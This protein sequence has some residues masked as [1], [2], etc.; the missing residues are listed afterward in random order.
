M[1]KGRKILPN[2]VKKLRG[3]D[4]PVRMRNEIST[5]KVISVNARNIKCLTTKRSRMIFT[6]KANQL[7]ALGILTTQDFESLAIYSNSLD[8]LFDCIE[9]LKDEKFSKVTTEK[10]FYWM[11][12]PYLKLYREMVDIVNKIGSEFG[13]TPVSRE[14]IQAPPVENDPLADLLRQFK[15]K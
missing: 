7:I 8:M 13:F 6:Q 5:E 2:A 3:T 4:Q 14:K 15:D 11:P 1:T 10:G 12:S 9:N